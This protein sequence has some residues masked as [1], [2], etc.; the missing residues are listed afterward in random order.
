MLSIQKNPAIYYVGYDP[1]SGDA[2]ISIVPE[3]NVHQL[4]VQTIPS[5][6]AEGDTSHLLKR[7][8]ADATLREVLRDGEYTIHLNGV[9][10]YLGELIREGRKGRIGSA[11]GDPNRYWSD[12][13]RILLLTLASTLIPEREFELRVVTALPVTL[14]ENTNRKQVKAALEN[15]YQFTY[16]GM[17]RK[18]VV[19]VGNVCVEGQGVLDRCGSSEGEQVVFDIGERTFDMVVA[20]GQRII[21]SHCK[22]KEIGVGQLVDDL[23]AF[24][25][26]HNANVGRKAHEILRAYA[27]RETLPSVTGITGT[28][29]YQEI[30]K[31]IKKASRTLE[32]FISSNLA[33]DGETIA[34]NFDR[35]YLAGG[36]AYYFG[37][38]I[39]KFIGADKVEIVEDA[40]LANALGYTNQAMGLQR[41]KYDIW[42]NNSYASKAG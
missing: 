25:K 28:E 13:S 5:V 42:E 17:P 37:D 4:A 19:K 34:S 24:G 8:S 16:N 14:Y 23:V 33:A 6:I 35:I 38:A 36:G 7:G 30:S 18:A 40:E 26:S 31:S 22:G 1:G 9:D 12:H 3:D 10:Y 15:M 29:L 41:K 2:T 20:D 21:V 32:S 39:K 11:I 27:H